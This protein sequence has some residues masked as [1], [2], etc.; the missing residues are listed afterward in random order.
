MM[1][2]S[3]FCT[4]FQRAYAELHRD[5]VGRFAVEQSLALASE[6]RKSRAHVKA[7]ATKQTRWAAK[8]DA[9]TERLRTGL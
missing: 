1:G 2:I 5:D 7:A 4:A 9:M 3:S 8:R 6:P